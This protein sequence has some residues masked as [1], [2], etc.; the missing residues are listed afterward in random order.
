MAISRE[1]VD[2]LY[3]MDADRPPNRNVAK[4]LP[5]SSIAVFGAG[6][7]G[8][9]A[10]Q[11][12]RLSSPSLLVLIDNS[13]SKL[14]MIPKELIEGVHCINSASMKTGEIAAKL[15]ELSPDGRG[16]DLALDCVGHATVITE[17]HDAVAKCG[18]LIQVGG[19]SE[20]TP[21]FVLSSHLSRGIT[22]RG[23]HQGDSV[24]KVSLPYMIDLW[25]KGRFKFDLMLTTYGFDELDKA[26]K[27]TH[28]GKVIKPVFVF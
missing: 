2:F 21:G 3:F 17:A 23:T 10:I 5:N 26:I 13:A 22:Y 9:S 14:D 7:V 19:S 20:A 6:A 24:P 4:P 18:T 28:D 12:A 11:A 27:D 16:V 15:R 8:L 25:H 1:R